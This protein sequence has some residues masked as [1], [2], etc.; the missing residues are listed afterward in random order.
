M[1]G[2]DMNAPLNITT[3]RP[4]WHAFTNA[5]LGLVHSLAHKI[6]G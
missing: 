5:S 2:G 4:R 1:Q 3:L 6:G